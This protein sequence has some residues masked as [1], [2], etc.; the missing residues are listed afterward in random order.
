LFTF[1]EGRN[2]AALEIAEQYV[3]AFGNL[4]RTNNTI[5]LPSNTGDMSS[6]IASAL[7]IY[8]NLQSKDRQGFLSSS[9]PV[10]ES[11]SSS[12]VSNDS[13]STVDSS[14]KRHIKKTTT[15]KDPQ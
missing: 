11:S 8:G 14:V 10:I 13:K 5:L 2:A 12:P 1:Q 4:A 9:T 7:A 6:M 3:H 15:E